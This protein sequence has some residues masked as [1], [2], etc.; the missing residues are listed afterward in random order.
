MVTLV[1]IAV[2]LAAFLLD[3]L[4]I[5]PWEARHLP[6]HA[7]DVDTALEFAVPRGV[8][9][10]PGHVWARVD[11]DGRTTVGIDDLARTV[12]GDLSMVDLPPVGDRLIAGR[13]AV[14]IRQGKRRLRLVAPLSGT[15]TDSNHELGRDPVQ[16]RWRPYKE[17]WMY[18]LEPEKGAAQEIALL[19]IGKD[20]ADWM[21]GEIDRLRQKFDEGKLVAPVEGALTRADEGTWSTFE[22]GFLGATEGHGEE[23]P[24]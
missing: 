2:L 8:F 1:F 3:V 20:A 16:L 7:A 5:R 14:V 12:I 17:G 15:V 9:F 21:D 24:P 18:R 23:V 19:R 4:L 13:S 11:D 6:K 10:H 22:C